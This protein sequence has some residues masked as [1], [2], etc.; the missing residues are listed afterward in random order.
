MTAIHEVGTLTKTNIKT[1]IAMMTIFKHI[2]SLSYFYKNLILANPR[3]PIWWGWLRLYMSSLLVM[4]VL[5]MLEL[6]LFNSLTFLWTFL[7][8]F[9]SLFSFSRAGKSKFSNLPLLSVK[10]TIS[11]SN[12]QN[13][14]WF[15]YLLL[16]SVIIAS[17]LA[18][19]DTDF[20]STCQLLS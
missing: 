19:K 14:N 1:C 6:T 2:G 9:S 13:W 11:K 15:V 10:C 8:F 3:L 20:L 5:L 16:N 12:H 18:Q 17:V 4:I 7:S